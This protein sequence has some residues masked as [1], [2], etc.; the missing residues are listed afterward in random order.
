M[1]VFRVPVGCSP[2]RKKAN[3]ASG[4]MDSVADPGTG[5]SGMIPPLFY[6]ICPFPAVHSLSTHAPLNLFFSFSCCLSLFAQT[7]V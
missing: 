1:N 2:P 6:S 4:G 7:T 5:G 3:R